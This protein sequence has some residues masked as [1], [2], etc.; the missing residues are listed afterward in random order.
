MQF[1]LGHQPSTQEPLPKRDLFS[2]TISSVLARR[3]TQIIQRRSESRKALLANKR[4]NYFD[5]TCS[6]V[7]DQEVEN[8]ELSFFANRFACDQDPKE[9]KAER[10]RKAK[11]NRE[12][13]AK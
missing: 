9:L 10:Q 11:R 5:D 2:C 6:V 13:K 4:Q 12:R 8:P 7:S 3:R 1:T